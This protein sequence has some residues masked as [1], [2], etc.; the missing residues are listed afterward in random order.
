MASCVDHGEWD[1]RFF[2]CPKCFK[3]GDVRFPLRA[4]AWRYRYGSTGMWKYVDRLEDVNPGE[5]YEV[6]PLFNNEAAT[7]SFVRPEVVANEP[8]KHHVERRGY[9]RGYDMCWCD[10]CGKLL[11][12][13][14]GVIPADKEKND[15]YGTWCAQRVAAWGCQ[16]ETDGSARCS[17][18]C[19]N[20]VMSV[21]AALSPLAH[22]ETP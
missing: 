16:S 9:S 13:S 8:C 22:K 17:R 21:N 4:V 2:A 15:D 5:H 7:A 1:S 10:G 19:G 18:A 3:G 6:E 14:D 11:W 20:C 12:A